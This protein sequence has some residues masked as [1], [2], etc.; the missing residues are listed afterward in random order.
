MLAAE[1]GLRDRTP[2]EAIDHLGV[3]NQLWPVY[4]QKTHTLIQGLM[5]QKPIFIADGHHRYETGLKFRETQ[6]AAGTLAGPDDPAAQ[7]GAEDQPARGEDE[8][9]G[10]QTEGPDEPDNRS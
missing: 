3:V 1:A 6:A 5:G 8:D 2:L 4:D 10:Q 9:C 7:G